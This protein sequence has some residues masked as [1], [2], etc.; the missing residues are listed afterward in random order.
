MAKIWAVF[1]TS[2]ETEA[3]S[4]FVRAEYEEAAREILRETI[5]KRLF[6]TK[7]GDGEARATLLDMLNAYADDQMVII[8]AT[9]ATLIG[10]GESLLASDLIVV[11]VTATVRMMIANLEKRDEESR[12]NLLTAMAEETNLAKAY[13]RHLPLLKEWLEYD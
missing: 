4:F 2:A 5:R 13:R 3:A 12:P 1:P 7:L 9:Q 10:V 6:K 11:D 8:S